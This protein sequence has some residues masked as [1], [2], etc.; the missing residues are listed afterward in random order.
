M[1]N[2]PIN[3]A[4]LNNPERLAAYYAEEEAREIRLE[5]LKKATEFISSLPPESQGAFW[6]EYFRQ[7]P[8]DQSA[9][10]YMAELM[11]RKPIPQAPRAELKI[12]PNPEWQKVRDLYMQERYAYVRDYNFSTQ[13]RQGIIAQ[14]VINLRAELSLGRK[15][16]I[17]ACM[18]WAR[19][20]GYSFTQKKIETIVF[21]LEIGTNYEKI[22][23]GNERLWA[24]DRWIKERESRGELFH[25][26]NSAID[27]LKIAAGSGWTNI[28]EHNDLARRNLSKLADGW[29]HCHQGS[30]WYQKIED[31]GLASLGV[32]TYFRSAAPCGT[33]A[34]PFCSLVESEREVASYDHEAAYG[35]SLPVLLHVCAGKSDG[36]KTIKE[37]VKRW[38]KKSDAKDYLTGTFGAFIATENG[39]ELQIM[40]PHESSSPF[41]IQELTRTW[42]EV[43]DKAELKA[44]CSGTNWKNSNHTYTT[45]PHIPSAELALELTLASE[46]SLFTLVASGKIDPQIAWEWWLDWVGTRPGIRGMNRVWHG[47]G[48]RQFKILDFIPTIEES[49]VGVKCKSEDEELTQGEEPKFP[50][51]HFSLESKA[52]K[53]LAHRIF[54][55]FH[56]L[57][58]VVGADPTSIPLE[59]KTW[60]P[61]DEK[62][63][64]YIFEE[65]GKDLEPLNPVYNLTAPELRAAAPNP[66]QG[67]LPPCIPLAQED[68]SI[69][70][71]DKVQKEPIPAASVWGVEIGT[72]N[73]LPLQGGKSQVNSHGKVTGKGQNRG[74][75]NIQTTSPKFTLT[76]PA[77]L[78]KINLFPEMNN[79][80][81]VDPESIRRGQ[82]ELRKSVSVENFNTIP[83]GWSWGQYA[84]R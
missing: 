76:A 36:P 64:R 3:P 54:S 41:A 10:G 5:R 39:Y 11:N 81:Q 43:G 68:L 35:L 71:C 83:N 2:P 46:R 78:P 59:Y 65:N 60:K 80:A 48:F 58:Y 1:I 73:H 40:L 15:D 56:G 4:V 20:T 12:D 38:V 25:T 26:L 72:V 53:G 9:A 28:G 52:R 16:T 66:A 57:G 29:K 23:P 14:L 37:M 62:R 49:I 67:T 32:E 50:R 7:Y 6:K 70:S 77:A 13:Y 21:D 17:K 22:A 63:A 44:T 69:Q 61:G 75:R 47:P 8:P 31:E 30:Y 34:C 27:I 24:S 42:S 19:V 51:S 84:G 55:P 33:P 18:E 74:P 45:T 79:P 82:V